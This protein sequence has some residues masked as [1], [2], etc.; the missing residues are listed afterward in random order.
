MVVR[1]LFLGWLFTYCTVAKAQYNT[2][3]NK[4]WIFG[5]HARVDFTSGSPVAGGISPATVLEGGTCVSNSAGNLLFYTDGDTVFNK[6]GMP[7]PS[8]TNISPYLTWSTSQSALVVPAIGDTN[9]YYIFS[10]EQQVGTAPDYC[11][12]TYSVVNMS[13]DGGLGD[14]VPGS[15]GLAMN[16]KMGEKLIAIPGNDCNIWV[17]AHKKDTSLFYVYEVNS[18][19]VGTPAIYNVGSVIPPVGP[20][21]DFG[22]FCNGV[23]KCSPDR[24]KII[25][26]SFRTGFAARGSVEIFDFDP[27]T[28]VI[29]NCQVIT[30]EGVY[31]AEFSPDNSKVYVVSSDSSSIYQYDLSLSSLASIQASRTKVSTGIVAGDI[32]LAPDGKLYFAG[33][34]FSGHSLGCIPF[35]NNAG[36]SCG[37]NSGAVDLGSGV[38]RMGLPNLFWRSPMPVL[39]GTASLCVGDP[40]TYVS[41]IPGGSWASSNSSVLSVNAATGAANALS[42][43]VDTLTYYAP[44]GCD[45]QL[46]VTVNISPSLLGDMIPLCVGETR[47]LSNAVA[48][49]TWSSSAIGVATIVGGTGA[50]TGVSAGTTFVTYTVG[51][52]SASTMLNVVDCPEGIPAANEDNAFA[53]YPIPAADRL[54][55]ILPGSYAGRGVMKMY[56]MAGRLVVFK[57]LTTGTNSI[58]L[59]NIPAGSYQ[60]VVIGDDGGFLLRK[61]VVRQ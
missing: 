34:G 19:G 48:G 51:G 30:S 57:A 47:T 50:C 28:G 52:C 35:P 39:S 3:E 49:G 9:K 55:V 42:A 15:V 23:M 26:A 38:P 43:G 5:V 46:V 61:L 32:K 12:L 14:L 44:D 27:A 58:D 4:V 40:A 25:M 60:C 54:E 41:T 13:L 22:P 21:V 31:G 2:N 37:F 59:H 16:E 20:V 18:A 17:V 1:F 56:D 33:S 7:M 24:T 45:V 11:H 10:M 6:L 8:G 53:I 29:S 36:T